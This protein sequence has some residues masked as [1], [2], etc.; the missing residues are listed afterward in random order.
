MMYD[1]RADADRTSPVGNAQHS[2]RRDRW[3]PH[4]QVDRTVAMSADPSPRPVVVMLHALGGSARAWDAVVAEVGD[5]VEPMPLDLPGFGDAAGDAGLGLETMVDGVAAAIR[6][7]APERWLIVGHSMGGKVATL[8]AAR[9]ERDGVLPGLAGVLLLAASP[10]APEP[11]AEDRRKRMIGWFEHGIASDEQAQEFV[12]A[13]V[14]GPLPPGRHAAAVADVRRSGRHAWLGWL[15]RGS[16]EDWSDAVG[17]LAAPAVIVAGGTDGDLGEDAQ[18]RLN[19]PHWREAL[20][21]VLAGAGHLLP[22]ERPA[23]VA[24]LILDLAARTRPALPARFAA[25]LASDRVSERTRRI[26]AERAIPDDLHAAPVALTWPERTLLRAVAA[27]VVPHDQAE[28]DLAARIDR[29]LAAG[30]GDGWR[31]A[32]LPDDLS[33]YRAGLA[34]LASAG[35]GDADGAGQDE[36]LHA[37]AAGQVAGG[38]LSG[39]QLAH[40]FEDLRAD[41][42]RLWMAHPA[43]MARIG[44]DGVANGGDG[45]RLQGYQRLGADDREGWESEPAR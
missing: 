35:F 9:A 7:R 31:F 43:T 38:G 11:M 26:M 16:R 13:N 33:A 1:E 23:E 34:A 41:A 5:A 6:A 42:V 3:R 21:A 17:T 27:R 45:A 24:A 28:L 8:V 19:A 22:L 4:G 30:A 25:L 29:Q 32:D 37:L 39:D 12:D 2:W 18:R 20:I 14:G 10:P 44:Y 15:E 36:M 40:W